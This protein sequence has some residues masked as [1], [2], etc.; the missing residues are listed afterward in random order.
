MVLKKNKRKIVFNNS[1]FYWYVRIDDSCHRL[2]IISDD[3]K[4]HLVYP[5]IDTEM[6]V[7]PQLVIECLRRII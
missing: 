7:T 3:K 6:P 4:I 2:H 1:V 5:F